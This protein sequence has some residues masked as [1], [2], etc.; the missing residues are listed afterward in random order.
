MS[1]SSVAAAA[2]AGAASSSSSSPLPYH[3][4]AA[5]AARAVRLASKL[6]ERVQA[7]LGRGEKSDKE[8]DSP[9]TVADYGAQALVAFSLTRTTTSPSLSPSAPFSMV[10][11]EDSADLRDP[12]KNGPRM[13]ERIAQLVNEVL[14]DEKL[15][16]DGGGGG[17]DAALPPPLSAEEVLSLIDLGGSA[18]GSE[19]RHWVLDPIDGTRGFVGKRQYAVCLALLDGGELAVG[20]LGCPNVPSDRALA[21][22]DGGEQEGLGQRRAGRGALFWGTRGGGAYVQ[23]LHS[24]DPE[25]K[26][27]LPLLD[28]SARLSVA[29][30][31]AEAE[32]DRA[33]VRFMESFDSRHSDFSTAARLAAALGVTSPSLRLDSQAKYGCLARGDA[34][35]NLR[36]PR[37]VGSFFFSFFGF[38]I[39]RVF[40]FVEGR[41]KKKRDKNS[42]FFP[43]LLFLSLPLP[44]SL[45]FLGLPREDLGPRPGRPAGPRGR[46]R[47]HRRCRR[48]ARLWERE[49]AR[50]RQGD[51]YGCLQGDPQGVDRGAE[52]W[53]GRRG[54]VKRIM[55]KRERGVIFRFFERSQAAFFISQEG[56]ER[57]RLA[58]EHSIS[59]LVF[60]YL[61]LFLPPIPLSLF[62]PSS[63]RWPQTWRNPQRRSFT[64]FR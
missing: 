35:I 50:P 29:A 2:G 32:R 1:T 20:V 51:R 17:D 24:D 28:A 13:T 64:T 49:V 59:R 39:F 23:P 10:A 9:V 33:T 27:S 36:F 46:R 7:T 52:A 16:G 11:E 54:R 40:G 57:E 3:A 53:R 41:K 14:R 12:A 37:K 47:R 25:G 55:G 34:A 45:V 58:G 30:A 63:T 4:E 62:C 5:A 38:F 15:V 8:D 56:S 31:G 18:G 19:G 21:D 48:G 6:C 44:L 22:G 43:P 60:L 26:D 61:S 42:L